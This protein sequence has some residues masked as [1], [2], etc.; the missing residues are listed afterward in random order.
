MSHHFSA[1][2]STVF[3]SNAKRKATKYRSC[4]GLR[5]QSAKGGFG[6]REES[7]IAIIYI[8]TYF[9]AM[10]ILALHGLG[11]SSSLLKEQLAP[12]M[13][14]LGSDYQFEFLD[15][16]IPCGRGPG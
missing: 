13:R 16:A 10:K 6:C 8:N 15:G 2:Q 7:H 3:E 9:K 11:S 14:V 4:P 5:R 12:F 1:G